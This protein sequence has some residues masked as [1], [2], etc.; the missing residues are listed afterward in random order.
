MST[1]LLDFRGARRR[2]LHE[3]GGHQQE[4]ITGMK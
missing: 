2:V 3:Q 1:S 4:V